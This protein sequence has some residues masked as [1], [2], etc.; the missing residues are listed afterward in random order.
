MRLVI[1]F[2]TSCCFFLRKRRKKDA[3]RVGTLDGFMRFFSLDPPG[4]IKP[5]DEP[6]DHHDKCDDRKEE[7]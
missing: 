6:D 7:P 3:G 5:D 4:S 1:I 2:P